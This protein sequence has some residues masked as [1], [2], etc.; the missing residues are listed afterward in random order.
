MSCLLVII[1]GCNENYISEK[2]T[3]FLHRLKHNSTYISMQVSPGFTTR[4]ELFTGK[5]PGTTDSFADFCFGPNA[6]PFQVF[7]VLKP[8]DKLDASANLIS[9]SFSRPKGNPVSVLTALYFAFT[10]VWIDFANIPLSLLPYFRVN[11]SIKKYKRSEKKRI[12]NNLMGILSDNGFKVSF[13]YGTAASISSKIT[14]YTAGD[15]EVIILHYGETD[16]I[17]HE[18]GPNS[19]EIKRTLGAI[20]ES[21]K[22]VYELLKTKLDQFMV[23]SDHDMT[24]ITDSVNLWE[25]LQQLDV[26]PIKDYLVFLNSPMARFCFRNKEAEQKIRALLGSL[27]KYGGEIT[28]EELAQRGLPADNKYGE[29][30]FWAHKGINFSPDF[31]HAAQIKGMHGY[32]D[33]AASIPLII[34]SRDRKVLPQKRCKIRDITPTVL[35]FL[36]LD[37]SEMD[38]KSLLIRD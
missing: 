31:Y 25:R 20:D 27:R 36:N 35:D 33:D 2:T 12:P 37:Y 24:E 26:R 4:V 23:F 22:N 18:Y 11:E 34:R 28:K 19:I 29:L 8:P 10:G 30:I 7:R 13:I 3:P 32:F 9:P 1:D 17:G 21:V 6:L 14:K 16:H 15:K 5:S 38:G